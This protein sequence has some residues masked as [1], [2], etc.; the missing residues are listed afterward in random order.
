MEETITQEPS[1]PDYPR[2]ITFEQVWA[3]LMEN[4]EL[5]KKTEIQAAKTEKQA[6]KTEK[7]FAI[8]EKQFAITEKQFVKT[9]KQLEKV[10]KQ[11]GGLGNSIGELIETLIAAR[12]WEKF[13]SYP[14]GFK[15]AY[16]RIPVFDD[17][18]H[19]ALTEIDILLYDTEWVMAVEVKHDVVEKDV[20]HHIKRMGRILEH[21][22][23][24][25]IGKK[26][27][28]A[29]AGGTVSPEAREF[30]YES[31]FFVLELKG[32]SVALIPPPDGFSPKEW[33]K[34]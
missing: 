4:R 12:L 30:A 3:A 16:R 7:Q 14:Y 11:L 6:A 27:L 28:G 23:P 34:T 25:I 32:E 24:M 31:G 1:I 15:R 22:P 8:T 29:I 19:R 33:R 9:E 18:T 10:M 20:E 2:G 13:S 21:P 5:Q 17:L 26:L